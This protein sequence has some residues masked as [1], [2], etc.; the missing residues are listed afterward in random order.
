MNQTLEDMIELMS[1]VSSVV[2]ILWYLTECPYS[3]RIFMLSI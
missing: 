3:Y 2:M 1:S